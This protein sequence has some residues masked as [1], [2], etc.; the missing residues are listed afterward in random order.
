MYCW[1]PHSSHKST[2]AVNGFPPCKMDIKGKMRFQ[3]DFIILVAAPGL[4]Y[5]SYCFKQ[6]FPTFLK[7]WYFVTNIVL[8]F[9]RKNCSSD[10]EKLL[11]F[12]AE[13]REFAKKILTVG[14]NNFWYQ[15]A[16]LTSWRLMNQNN[17]KSNWKKI[18]G[19]RNMQEK[20]ENI[21]SNFLACF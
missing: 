9:L 3:Y 12:E 21:F 10:R 13:G 18:L 8:T 7:Q 4:H 20:L 11:K 16:F 6:I 17:K 5:I 2:A 14:P 1:A 19:F 15:N